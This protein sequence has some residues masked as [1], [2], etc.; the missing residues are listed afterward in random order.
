[1]HPTTCTGTT[2]AV[3]FKVL[4]IVRVTTVEELFDVRGTPCSFARNNTIASEEAPI[5]R[6]YRIE[7]GIV[8]CCSYTE[9]GLRQ[10]FAFAGPGDLI[11]FPDLD[12]WHFTAEAVGPVTAR[13]LKPETL[14]AALLSEHCIAKALRRHCIGQFERRERHLIWLS[15][16]QSEDRLLAFLEDFGEVATSEGSFVNLPM[17]RQDL[18]DHLG[19]TLETV[20]RCFGCLK[21]RGAIEMDGANR[22]RLRGQQGRAT[23]A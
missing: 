19:M 3:P 2:A 18:G 6:V 11:G 12:V 22:Y 4:S 23:A 7:S 9:D 1:M 15:H 13:F 8:R 5:E 21:R 10:I 17:T 14:D 16:L 20:S